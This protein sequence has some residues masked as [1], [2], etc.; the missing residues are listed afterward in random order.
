MNEI[1]SMVGTHQEGIIFNRVWLFFYAVVDELIVII[2][3]KLQDM[4]NVVNNKEE[5]EGTI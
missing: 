2:M 4:K 5:I 3:L 1:L